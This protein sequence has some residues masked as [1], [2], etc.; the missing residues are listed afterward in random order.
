[1]YYE[2]VWA[3]R[4]DADQRGAVLWMTLSVLTECACSEVLNTEPTIKGSPSLSAKG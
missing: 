2:R 4:R 3:A 1:M